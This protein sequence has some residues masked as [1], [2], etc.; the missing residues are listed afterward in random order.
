MVSLPYGPCSWIAVISLVLGMVMDFQDLV[1][2]SELTQ[3]TDRRSS[4]VLS[5]FA[6]YTCLNL[7][8][9]RIVL[10]VVTCGSCSRIISQFVPSEAFMRSRCARTDLLRLICRMRS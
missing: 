10:N 8:G 5:L 1:L 4:L 6:G 9:V 2:I 7:F 3:I